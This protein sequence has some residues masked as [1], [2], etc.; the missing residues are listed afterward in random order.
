MHTL[1]SALVR[2]VVVALVLVF[3]NCAGNGSGQEQTSCLVGLDMKLE[4]S[5][6]SALIRSFQ[7]SESEA[8]LVIKSCGEVYCQVVSDGR[9]SHKTVPIPAIE[10]SCE[11]ANTDGTIALAVLND[12]GGDTLRFMVWNGEAWSESEILG[13]RFSNRKFFNVGSGFKNGESFRLVKF[14]DGLESYAL[15][16]ARGGHL[17]MVEFVRPENLKEI[18]F[19]NGSHLVGYRELDDQQTNITL[20][21]YEVDFSGEKVELV[22]CSTLAVPYTVIKDLENNRAVYTGS[23]LF[24]LKANEE[25]GP[26]PVFLTTT[27]E[28]GETTIL[29]MTRGRQTL[30]GNFK[31]SGLWSSRNIGILCPEGA[32]DGRGRWLL[33]QIDVETREVRDVARIEEV[34]LLMFWKFGIGWMTPTSCFAFWKQSGPHDL[35]YETPAK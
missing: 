21:D 4:L 2:V 31:I 32:I 14:A 24:R 34:G 28:D 33:K 8:V 22:E 29:E 6:R 3:V 13:M 5:K 19:V 18:V 1:D 25:L 12:V 16:S 27:G 20:V 15:V 7:I 26:G 10:V 23:G 30:S 9:H 35:R 11:V 17:R